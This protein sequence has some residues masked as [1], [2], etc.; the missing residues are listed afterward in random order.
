MTTR[1][2]P[3][4]DAKETKEATHVAMI[5]VSTW[6]VPTEAELIPPVQILTARSQQVDTVMEQILQ[7]IQVGSRRASCV[8]GQWSER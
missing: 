8:D 3:A 5:D 6:P 7:K 1:N 4:K 2:E